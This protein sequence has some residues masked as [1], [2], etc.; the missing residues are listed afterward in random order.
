[1]RKAAKVL[2]T[3]VLCLPLLH[4]C[5]SS[6]KS[7]AYTI[8]PIGWLINVLSG[9]SLTTV[10]VQDESAPVVVT[11]ATLC[12][13]Y[14]DVLKTSKAFFHI[15]NLEPYLSV[16]D[17]EIRDSGVVEN[18]LSSLNAVYDFARY[19][20]VIENGEIA[21]QESSYYEGSIFDNIDTTSKDLCLWN[22][23]I[24]MLSMAGNIRDWL[25]QTKPEDGDVYDENYQ[26]LEAE[27]INLDAKY[28]AYAT[29]LQEEKKTISFVTITASFGN[30]QK[31]YGFQV[32]PLILSK[33][34]VL[35]T[36][37]QL[38]EI[39]KEIKTA[40]VK[41]IVYESNINQDMIALYHQVQADLNL[42]EVDL[43]NLSALT[44]LQ[45]QNGKDYL[46]IMYENLA[47]L[48]TIQAQAIP[49]AK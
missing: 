36:D 8:Y 34:G 30:W 45:Q 20:Q 33:Y 25:K 31:T 28:Q 35:P 17:Q 40:G 11:N 32:Y 2:L 43:S 23:P 6:R 15:G 49:L 39:E 29:S 7:V 38:K 13:N 46:S 18:D 14:K 37:E 5:A 19:R 24:A 44:V 12:S 27:L 9:N 47:Q 22:D 21:F 1:M 16:A 48:E 3:I 42:I 26:K 4:G 41:Y 10:S